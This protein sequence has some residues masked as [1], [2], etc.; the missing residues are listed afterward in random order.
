MHSDETSG[1]RVGN[2]LNLSIANAVYTQPMHKDLYVI[3][4]ALSVIDHYCTPTRQLDTV[5]TIKWHRQLTTRVLYTTYWYLP[6]YTVLSV[7]ELQ[8]TPS[9]H[10]DTVLAI[11]WGNQLLTNARS[12]HI[13]PMCT[14]L[15][16]LYSATRCD[17]CSSTC[18]F[19]S[20][21]R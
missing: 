2:Q 13:W 12:I 14:Y 19:W 17:F 15:S 6:I 1:H 10:L 21:A 4:T 16:T 3:Y 5:L 20:S 9:R 11:T 8:C 7:I 18:V